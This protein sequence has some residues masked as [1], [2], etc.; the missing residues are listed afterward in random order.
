MK[1]LIIII[2][3]T[4]VG[5]AYS[6]DVEVKTGSGKIVI[7][8]DNGTWEYKIIEK[9]NTEN[10]DINCDYYKNEIDDFTGDE[11]LWTKSIKFGKTKLGSNVKFQFRAT[12][13]KGNN[14]IAI[15]FTG[16]GDI[17]C[18]SQMSSTAKLKFSDG[19]FI[20]LTHFGNTD[21]GDYLEF[22]SILH[23][24]DDALGELII[25]EEDWEKFNTLKIEM[26]RIQGSEYYTDVII[27]DDKQDYILKHL[28]CVK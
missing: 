16:F 12:K 3:F 21:C 4:F 5:F 7:L 22:M 23:S 18:V 17:G 13:S 8:H 11:K 26:I 24:S 19:E 14:I 10:L 27:D 2:L 9:I 28:N 1:K 15:S 25:D 20:E 6:Q